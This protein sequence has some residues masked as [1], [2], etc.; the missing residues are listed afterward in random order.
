MPH[1]DQFPR[2]PAGYEPSVPLAFRCTLRDGGLDVAWV[3]VTGELDIATAPILEQTL[4]RA[5]QRARR[6]VLDLREL[7]FMDT[8][9]VHVI[10]DGALR[11]TAADRRLVLVRGPAQVDRVLDLTT[12]SDDL[13][14][15][16]LDPVEPPVQAL[17]Q[18]AHGERAA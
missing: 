4:R 12:A 9:G 5:E 1:T 2:S 11:A 6:I 14:I 8:S 7:A 3:R 10:V 17:I 13:E 16:D 18:L 15:V